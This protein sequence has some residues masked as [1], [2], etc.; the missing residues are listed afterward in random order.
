MPEQT[1]R[2][3]LA[4]EGAAD[5]R[6]TLERDLSRDYDIICKNGSGDFAVELLDRHADVV[7]LDLATTKEREEMYQLRKVR[8]LLPYTPVIVTSTEENTDLVVRAMKFGAFDFVAKPYTPNRIRIALTQAL[9]TKGLRNE[10]DYLR[11]EQNVVYDFDRIIAESEP[12]RE[13]IRSL[14]KF[15]ATDATILMTGETGTGKSFLSGTIHFNSHRGHRPFVVINCANIQETLL[16]SELFGHEKG[17]FTGADKLRV[18]R[19]EQAHGGTVFLDEIGEMSMGL[20]AKLLR[21]LEERAFER[22]GGNRTIYTDVRI[23]AATN[24]NLTKQIAEGRFREDLFYRINVLPVK[25]PSLRE[26]PE[27]LEPLAN[28]LLRQICRNLRKSITGFTPE[29]VRIINRYDWPGNIRQLA[30]MIERA[31]ILEEREQIHPSSIFV[32][33]LAPALGRQRTRSEEDEI[34]KKRIIGVL[35]K[36]SWVQKR[37]AAELEMSPR[38]LNYWVRK[39]RITHPRWHRNK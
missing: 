14:K 18:G 30:N 7:L 39:L 17:S 31:V 26:R 11:H 9:E 4:F 23:I 35:E 5:W 25:L 32:P 12:M 29:V 34:E 6:K 1:T 28:A 27:C 33:D 10:I 21:V 2:T 13:V 8:S 38:V 3:I 22:V 19:F 15:A 16:E 36:Y 37:A 24:R 20:Q